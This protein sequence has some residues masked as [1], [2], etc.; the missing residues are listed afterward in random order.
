MKIRN[1]TLPYILQP[2]LAMMFLV[3][4]IWQSVGYLPYYQYRFEDEA[5][6]DM[7]TL[8]G[9]NIIGDYH[10][11]TLE[12][13]ILSALQKGKIAKSIIPFHWRNRYF[14][15]IQALID[16]HKDFVVDYLFPDESLDLISEYVRVTSEWK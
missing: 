10:F 14:P 12:G 1:S 3:I 5:F 2:T 15:F 16:E 7:A 6:V 13:Y 9:N 8:E 11:W 4:T